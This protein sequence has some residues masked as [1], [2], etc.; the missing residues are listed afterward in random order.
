M[1]TCTTG[2]RVVMKCMAARKGQHD[3]SCYLVARAFSHL[4]ICIVVIDRPSKRDC[5]CNTEAPISC[6]GLDH[7]ADD[8]SRV[9]V[10]NFLRH[11]RRAGQ[12]DSCQKESL[13]FKSDVDVETM[14]GQGCGGAKGSTSRRGSKELAA[15]KWIRHRLDCGSS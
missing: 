3:I 2:D 4:I 9:A 1:R 8:R 10:I 5:Q 14:E 13:S 6:S 11:W 15:L 7:L 12:D